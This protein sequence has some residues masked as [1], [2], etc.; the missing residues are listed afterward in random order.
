MQRF[1]NLKEIKIHLTLTLVSYEKTF[2]LLINVANKAIFHQNKIE[3]IKK[4]LK[5]FA[6]HYISINKNQ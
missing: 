5:N 6:I 3:S 2:L 1:L 4:D